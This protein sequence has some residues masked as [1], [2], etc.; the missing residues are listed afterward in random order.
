MSQT[1]T[2]PESQAATS[3]APS[4]LIAILFTRTPAFNTAVC[5]QVS[6]PHS[7]IEPSWAAVAATSTAHAHALSAAA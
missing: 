1:L 6:V 7:K 3:F 5:S 4:E 2:R